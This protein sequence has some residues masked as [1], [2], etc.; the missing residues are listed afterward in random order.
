MKTINPRNQYRSIYKA[1]DGGYGDNIPE[2]FVK[3][4]RSYIKNHLKRTNLTLLP[5]D[6]HPYCECTGFITDGNGYFVYFSSG[7]Y[8][9]NLHGKRGDDWNNNVLIRGCK[10]EKDFHGFDNY[11]CKLCE[12]PEMA[13]KIID[14]MK[15]VK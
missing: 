15:R 8:R 7:D 3:T 4:Y 12:I 13:T 11:Y 5:K 2:K 1:L 10:D 9:W 6:S 14:E